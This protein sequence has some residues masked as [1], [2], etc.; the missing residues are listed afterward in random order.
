MANY[1]YRVTITR[2]CCCCCCTLRYCPPTAPLTTPPTA[3]STTPPT[4]PSTI[5][6]TVRI[7]PRLQSPTIKS[8]TLEEALLLP[9]Y[10]TF[11]VLLPP[12]LL[13]RIL[14]RLLLRRLPRVTYCYMLLIARC[15]LSINVTYPVVS[16]IYRCH[17]RCHLSLN[18]TYR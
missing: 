12:R 11:T 8:Y 5:P 1:V 3:P 14:P 17:F 7:L 10:Y 15:H 18:I 6:P 2:C 13:P 16:L 4:A 9:T